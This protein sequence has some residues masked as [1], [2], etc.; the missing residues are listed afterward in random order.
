MS[1]TDIRVRELPIYGDPFGILTVMGRLFQQPK[2]QFNSAKRRTIVSS[3]LKGVGQ[4]LSQKPLPEAS[5][6]DAAGLRLAEALGADAQDLAR[7]LINDPWALDT[8]TEMLLMFSGSSIKGNVAAL[9]DATLL[10]H[11]NNLDPTQARQPSLYLAALMQNRLLSALYEALKDDE[12][13]L[14]VEADR[15]E[16]V[17]D[18]LQQVRNGRSFLAELIHVLK[19]N[20]NNGSVVLKYKEIAFGGKPSTDLQQ[21]IDHLLQ[22]FAIL[23]LLREQQQQL[24]DAIKSADKKSLLANFHEAEYRRVD[25]EVIQLQNRFLKKPELTEQTSKLIQE[26]LQFSQQNADNIGVSPKPGF[27]TGCLLQLA[28]LCTK[29]LVQVK[30]S[31][32]AIPESLSTL[33]KKSVEALRGRSDDPHVARAINQLVKASGG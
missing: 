22:L 24:L 6:P 8:R 30:R 28:S 2:T 29:A 14:V 33:S 23:P 13:R 16:R 20:S 15:D 17:K 27:E 10:A 32:E 19:V 1:L 26:A 5:G 12:M 11:V 3:A 31:G 9:M 4:S 25:I 21:Q 7:H 18:Q